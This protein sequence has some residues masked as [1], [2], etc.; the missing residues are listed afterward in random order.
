M[1]HDPGMS[2]NRILG[3]LFPC[4]LELHEVQ[5][6]TADRE[7]DCPWQPPTTLLKLVGIL[8]S[9]LTEPK[10]QSSCTEGLFPLRKSKD[11]GKVIP[12][13]WDVT[14]ALLFY[15]QSP[16]CDHPAALDPPS[17]IPVHLIILTS[18]IF[19]MPFLSCA[20]HIHGHGV[21]CLSGGRGSL[22]LCWPFSLLTV[23]FYH[24]SL[25]SF[26]RMNDF[27]VSCLLLG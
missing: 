18:W 7:L 14:D 20:F 22:C 26:C 2:S 19:I 4:L 12:V 13:L 24:T 3:A 16:S 6:W 21:P 5:M 23:L 17:I 15:I 8:P 1:E 11:F 10:P 25:R 27:Q 9:L